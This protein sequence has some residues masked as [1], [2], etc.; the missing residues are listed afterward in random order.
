MLETG[1]WQ[2]RKGLSVG[3]GRGE[4]VD[5]VKVNEGW[6]GEEEVVEPEMR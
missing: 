3:V 1:D 5:E 4:G 2:R 6:E